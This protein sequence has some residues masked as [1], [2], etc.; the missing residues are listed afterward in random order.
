MKS[1][2]LE[3]NTLLVRKRKTSFAHIFK[4]FIIFN[5]NDSILNP[6]KGG[7]S[8]TSKPMVQDKRRLKNLE[9]THRKPS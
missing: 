7:P 4:F 8:Q 1:T 2:T 6:E 3:L 9:I 5:V